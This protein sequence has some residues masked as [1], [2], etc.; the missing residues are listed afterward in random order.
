MR[1]S[2]IFVICIVALLM[3]AGC[4]ERAGQTTKVLCGDKICSSTENCQTCLADC[5]CPKGQKC[6]RAGEC[7][8]PPP[9]PPVCGDK[10][11]ASTENCGTCAADCGCASGQVCENNA[12]VTPPPPAAPAIV[13][14]TVTGTTAPDVEVGKGYDVIIDRLGTGSI[15][16]NTD[17]WL[18]LGD[19]KW[20]KNKNSDGGV[21]WPYGLKFT[22]GHVSKDG[23]V[24][25]QKLTT[26]PKMKARF[27][28]G[29]QE[30]YIIFNLV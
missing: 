9:P 26:P 19:G 21:Q 7:K 24:F 28:C 11:C 10:N 1:K 17:V 20:G 30:K 13:T 6:N 23:P 25:E 15:C 3:L 18:D 22:G 27:M 29:T 16:V 2:V 5:P 8:A 12:C 14:G 4:G